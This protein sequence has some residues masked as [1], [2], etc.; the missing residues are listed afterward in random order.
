MVLTAA[1]RKVIRAAGMQD[2]LTAAKG[3][4][5]KDRSL[6]KHEKDR[7]VAK[8]E[9][10]YV[11]TAVKVSES[12]GV[13][14]PESAHVRSVQAD[15]EAAR[16]P[17]TSADGAPPTESDCQW[18]YQN[19]GSP[20]VDVSK[21]PS[22]GAYGLLLQAQQDTAIYKW[23]LDHL[24]PKTYVPEFNDDGRHAQDLVGVP[25]EILAKWE[26]VRAAVL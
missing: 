26:T 8:L 13:P 20:K 21:A 14:T 22:L 7:A 10:D 16:T 24:S 23:V 19:F 3:K 1:Q 11:D 5:R 25:D 6:N 2:G 15:L 9:Q 12:G 17:S 4:I 18:V